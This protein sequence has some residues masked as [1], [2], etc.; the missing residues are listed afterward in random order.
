MRNAI[1][2][3]GIALMLLTSSGCGIPVRTVWGVPVAY[4]GWNAAVIAPP[5]SPFIIA[6]GQSIVI[7]IQL[8]PI[9]GFVLASQPFFNN[10]FVAN[11]NLA[12]TCPN[13]L[14]VS[15]PAIGGFGTGGLPTVVIPVVPIGIGSC[16]LPI[17]LG[18]SGVTVL[19]VSVSSSH[20]SQTSAVYS[21]KVARRR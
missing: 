3:F 8:V 10:F 17:N 12:L 2:R 13:I 11:P 19:N 6:P 9:N 7:I 5:S 15:A 16:L 14:T 18:L 4:T 1:A 20:S 21:V